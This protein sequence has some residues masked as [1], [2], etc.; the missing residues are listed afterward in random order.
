M[1][2]NINDLYVCWIIC[3]VSAYFLSDK[4]YWKIHFIQFV[5]VGTKHISE[6]FTLLVILIHR[7]ESYMG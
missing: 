2:I 7:L 4:N 3:L 5:L 1:I 6:N